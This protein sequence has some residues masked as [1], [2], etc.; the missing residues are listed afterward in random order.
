MKKL[1]AMFVLLCSVA[2]AQ[3]AVYV[4]VIVYARRNGN[5]VTV[6][7]RITK[8]GVVAFDSGDHSYTKDASETLAQ[9]RA[10]VVA[11]EKAAL[12]NQ[13]EQMKAADAAEGTNT[14]ESAALAAITQ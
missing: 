13:I 11:A 3:A 10:R 4:K 2:S 12:D 1:L 5:T 14:D 6:R 9:F 8:D 7:E